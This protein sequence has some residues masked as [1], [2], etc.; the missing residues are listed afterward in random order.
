[1]ISWCERHWKF[2]V[3]IFIIL[4]IFGVSQSLINDHYGS[5]TSHVL[6]FCCLLWAP[7][8]DWTLP[9]C[10]WSWFLVH[11]I[12]AESCDCLRPHPLHI[13]T[14]I[15]FLKALSLS[16]SCV[17]VGYIFCMCV[18][19]TWRISDIALHPV[20]SFMK[21]FRR[22][23]LYLNMTSCIPVVCSWCNYTLFSV[24]SIW[25]T[26]GTIDIWPCTR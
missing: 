7:R 16:H 21:L 5:F 10:G 15:L 8:P 19:S 26:S 11:F 4:P 25:V 3:L 20:Q 22:V 1:M 17:V 13:R 14:S 24:H 23:F 6:S 2:T 18:V 12:H 9:K